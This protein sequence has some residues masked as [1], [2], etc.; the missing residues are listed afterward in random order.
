MF[1]FFVHNV[2]H[3]AYHFDQF[4]LRQSWTWH[5][6]K[7]VPFLGHLYRQLL[8]QRKHRSLVAIHFGP[9]VL[10]LVDGAGTHMSEGRMV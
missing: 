10:L 5:E 7:L 4:H 8:S 1:K 6:S 2:F 9:I 3:I